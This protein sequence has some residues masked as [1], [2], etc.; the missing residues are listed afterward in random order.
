MAR[1]DRNRH[2]PSPVFSAAV[3]Q[4]SSLVL[5][6][7][8]KTYQPAHKFRQTRIRGFYQPCT[9]CSPVQGE[10]CLRQHAAA[11]ANCSVDSSSRPPP[12]TLF[13]L[14]TLVGT[15]ASPPAGLSA[16]A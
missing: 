2:A 6:N 5:C 10:P 11:A 4:P 14:Y 13:L 12:K 3:S 8:C 1:Q 7:T 16:F 15:A 9:D